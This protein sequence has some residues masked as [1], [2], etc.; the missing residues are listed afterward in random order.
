MGVAFC[1]RKRQ[2]R[3]M[4]DL[5]EK[6]AGFV[7][8]SVLIWGA[9]LIGLHGTLSRMQAPSFYAF[10]SGFHGEDQLVLLPGRMLDYGTIGFYDLVVVSALGACI[11][12]LAVG[13]LITA[14][15]QLRSSNI[16][17][18]S[19]GLEEVR[20]YTYEGIFAF[21]V[22][23]G[24]V[25]VALLPLFAFVFLQR[26]LTGLD[27]WVSE[28]SMLLSMVVTFT[29]IIVPALIFGYLNRATVGKWITPISKKW[30]FYL[31]FPFALSYVLTLESVYT[32]TVSIDKSLYQRSA[33]KYLQVQV[34]LGGIT[35]NPNL[36]AL[37]VHG[38]NNDEAGTQL[39]VLQSA[40]DGRYFAFVPLKQIATGS[41]T[42]KLTFHPATVS[43]VGQIFRHRVESTAGFVV[44]D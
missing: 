23:T 44:V 32:A 31:L 37:T 18:P 5:A 7:S 34:T 21:T 30:L 11:V 2:D 43:E 12:V 25:I 16:S 1:I 39:P 33:D 36:A 6:R 20:E 29:L 40:G 8:G 3:P 24:L 4:S 9:T 14:G 26:W 41:H 38:R 15:M 10:E 22:I 13:H 42:V 17:N 19:I 27:G 35:S 28:V